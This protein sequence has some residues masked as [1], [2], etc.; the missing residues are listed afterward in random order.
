M[1]QKNNTT[2]PTRKTES[3]APKKKN[4]DVAVKIKTHKDKNGGHPHIIVEDIDDKHVSVGLTHDMKK[5]KNS[6]NY[7]LESKPLG[8][9]KTSYIHRQGTVDKKTSYIGNRTGKVTKKDYESVKK[10]ADKAKNKYI[11]KKDKKK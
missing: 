11:E 3:T 6:T 10:Y 1:K 9:K 5:G 8:G 2:K 7:P 4:D